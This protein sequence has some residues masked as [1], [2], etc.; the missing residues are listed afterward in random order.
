[1]W[2]SIIV[3]LLV[4]PLVVYSTNPPYYYDILTQLDN[5]WNLNFTQKFGPANTSCTCTGGSCS[6][7]ENGPSGT[8]GFFCGSNNTLINMMFY[9]LSGTI[10]PETGQLTSLGGVILQSGR[11]SGSIPSSFSNLTNLQQLRIADN[12]LSGTLPILSSKITDLELSNNNF[13][14]S[15]DIGN[16]VKVTYLQLSNNNFSGNIDWILNL[17]SL[18]N[19]YLDSNSFSGTLPPNYNWN[20]ITSLSLINNSFSGNIPPVFL[21]GSYVGAC[22]LGLNYFTQCSFSNT[23]CTINC[24]AT[25]PHS[26]VP[27]SPSPTSLTQAPTTVS[28]VPTNPSPNCITPQP[29]STAIC[30]NHTWVVM[31]DLQIENLTIN[32]EPLIIKGS[33][34]GNGTLTLIGSGPGLIVTGS[35]NIEG[36]L[37]LNPS[38][39]NIQ[40]INASQINGKFNQIKAKGYCGTK[41]SQTDQSLSV[42]LS[43]HCNNKKILIIVLASVLGGIFIIAIFGIILYNKRSFFCNS[44]EKEEIMEATKYKLYTS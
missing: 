22:N 25:A 14:G 23:S 33:Y 27:T 13:M 1:M 4:L 17:T 41:V 21:N 29:V 44:V 12:L 10:P 9:N 39:S 37:V 20:N 38:S 18:T 8:I 16:L 3:Y 2:I 19:L 24:K 28:S 32:V 7:T 34:F 35:A 15:P 42:L 26:P 31:G 40:V 43:T 36:N 6:W 5:H 30:Q 11:L